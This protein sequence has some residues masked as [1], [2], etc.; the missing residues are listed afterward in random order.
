M[1]TYYVYIQ[2]ENMSYNGCNLYYK[3]P[4]NI[5]MHKAIEMSDKYFYYKKS[6]YSDS[7][8][9]LGKY[10]YKAVRS[11]NCRYDDYDYDVYEFTEDYISCNEKG[12]IYCKGIP[13]SSENMICFD[14]MYYQ[15]Y[16]IY[17]DKIIL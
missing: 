7:Y 10:K 5:E 2:I 15:E 13:E 4:I 3:K 9:P 8:I 11:S 17:Y 14:N 12:I 1:T 16:P 6:S